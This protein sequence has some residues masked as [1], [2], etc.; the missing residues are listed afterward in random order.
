MT[1]HATP[2]SNGILNRRGRRIPLALVTEWG[3]NDSLRVVCPYCLRCHRHGINRFRLR[4]QTRAA[5][6]SPEAG[7]YQLCYPFEEEARAQYSYQIDKEN[8]LFVTVGIPLPSD[9]EDEESEDEESEDEESEEADEPEDVWSPQAEQDEQLGTLE[10]QIKRLSI[11]DTETPKVPSRAQGMAKLMQ[12]ANDRQARFNAC[13]VR[14][15][16]H[17]IES[18]FE[19]YKDD[20]FVSQRSKSGYH[21]ITLAASKGHVRILQFL[22]SKGG[23]LNTADKRGRTPLMEAAL[24]GRAQAVDFLLN[25]DADPDVQDKKGRRAYF[26]ALPSR[27]TARIEPNH[28]HFVATTNAYGAPR[29]EFYQQTM[30]YDVPD[31]N[32]TIARL[33]RG[34]LF[35][36]VSAA[37]GWGTGWAVRQI[38]PNRLW[39]DRVLGLC[40]LIGYTLQK[41]GRDERGLPGSFHS[42]HAE[43]KLMAYYISEHVILR[44]ELFNGLADSEIGDWWKDLEL[45]GLTE[46]CPKIPTVKARIQVSRGICDECQRFISRIKTVFG[47][48]FEVTHCQWG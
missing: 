43:K 9:D 25:N 37:S 6:C 17:R 19:Q 36:V 26:Y 16:L 44:R 33:D 14:N 45:Q 40:R 38:L 7:H 15:D 12:N 34:S 18:L 39:R 27:K 32:K 4:G 2:L 24:W 29:I 30:V 41:D 22:H 35:P 1:T 28:G 11:G 47:V 42:S 10:S 8:G 46:L 3:K 21:C 13:C 5:H 31:Q 20:P 23:D 48:S